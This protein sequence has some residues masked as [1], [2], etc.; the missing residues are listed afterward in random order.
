MCIDS[1]KGLFIVHIFPSRHESMI[2][3]NR[4]RKHFRSINESASYHRRNAS[5]LRSSKLE[6]HLCRVTATSMNSDK[7]NK[8]K[9]EKEEYQNKNQDHEPCWFKGINLAGIA[10]WL[11]LFHLPQ[12]SASMLSQLQL[13][14]R[15]PNSVTWSSLCLSGHS[16][17]V[18][19]HLKL[20]LLFF[21]LPQFVGQ[22]RNLLS[23]LFEA[24][25]GQLWRTDFR[26][27]LTTLWTSQTIPRP[28]RLVAHRVETREQRRV[29]AAT[30]RMVVQSKHSRC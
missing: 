5:G 14:V 12:Q 27:N 2:N 11:Q 30:K 4:M 18:G 15:A 24:D 9:R 10:T 17:F 16:L 1:H 6:L 13:G 25:P 3:R 7:L 20:L 29:E 8:K 28:L 21:F 22:A 26:L 23:K 19:A